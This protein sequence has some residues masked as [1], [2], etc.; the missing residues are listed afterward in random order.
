MWT[1]MML[2]A[3]TQQPMELPAVPEPDAH[4]PLRRLNRVEYD[5]TVR[6]LLG[7]RLQPG[8]D[9][10]ED[11]VIHGF[12]NGA[13]A[14][15]VSPVLFE[16]YERAA[17]LLLEDL[18]LPRAEFEEVVIVSP[19]NESVIEASAGSAS[20]DGYWLPTGAWLE[21]DMPL[22]FDGDY[23]LSVTVN[24]RQGGAPLQLEVFDEGVWL[25]QLL[26]S[27]V[28][29]TVVTLDLEL[30]LGEHR[31]RLLRS[32]EVSD[33]LRVDRMVLSGPEDTENGPSAAY[34]GIVF[35]D[36]GDYANCAEDILERF[37]SRA[38][39]RTL[40]EDDLAEVMA[41]YRE[42][43]DL[44]ASD[45]QALQGTMKF[46]LLAP[47]FL[48]R[49][50]PEPPLNTTRSL[51]GEEL[52]TRL[53]YL[54]WSTTPDAELRSAAG[55]GAL[56]S[57][58]GRAQQIA[59]MLEDPKADALALHF[60]AQWFGV[61]EIDK[62]TP[63]PDKHPEFDDA[64][65]VAMQDELREYG[66]EF[67]SRDAS[68]A[69]VLTGRQVF[70]NH[71]LAAFYGAEAVPWSE[72]VVPLSGAGQHRGGVLRSAAFLGGT[73]S[74]ESA[75]SVR[76]GQMVVER[77]L[78]WEIPPPPPDV[79]A[80]IQEAQP[81]LS[82]RENEEL[83]RADQYCQSCHAKMDHAG[84]AL[85][86]YGIVGDVLSE[87]SA[88]HLIDVSVLSPEGTALHGATGLGGWI[89]SHPEFA[90]CAATTLFTYGMGRPPEEADHAAV[91]AMEQAFLTEGMRF[92]PMLLALIESDSFL[93]L[94][95]EVVQ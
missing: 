68:L 34:E 26:V 56:L 38:W 23:V 19:A 64:L 21:A 13:G 67:V 57:Q 72:G 32:D 80:V 86:Q 79:E 93:T 55:N 14:L 66:R 70:G 58:E 63:N 53:S 71:T 69:E 87:D 2:L 5:H 74:S 59:R 17:D 91:D 20:A 52:A 50:E 84:F 16:H 62:L 12:D 82:D 75:S 24:A 36:P 35:C 29:Q 22:Q 49:I 92:E 47:D 30:G 83:Q 78:C 37:G 15:A 39:R 4:T 73:S 41:V 18:F 61:R 44:G 65:R 76:R 11:V 6:D 51:S 54:L 7:A 10:P 42:L 60:A 33:D 25:G 9:F 27:P 40:S 94:T 8:R 43:Q 88:G 77:F 48:F 31:I 45:L 81:G 85:G 1:A 95:G 28:G 90:T 3:C 46:L 89:T